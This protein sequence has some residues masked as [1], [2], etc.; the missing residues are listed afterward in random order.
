M[1][2][3]ILGLRE[4]VKKDG[5][6]G[7]VTRFFNKGWQFAKVEEVFSEKNV[8]DLLKN[9]PEAEKYNLYFTVADCMK[10]REMSFQEVI[11]FDV[12]KIELK[13]GS[14]EEKRNIILK[15]REILASLIPGAL[16]QNIASL[17]SGHG[18]QLF[19][20]IEEQ[21]LDKSVFNVYG[22]S[23]K[24]FCREYSRKLAD[25]GIV[26]KEVD[27][28]AFSSARLMRLPCTINRKKN[29]EDAESFLVGEYEPLKVPMFLEKEEVVKEHVIHDS[30]LRNYL[31]PDTKGVLTECHFLN[32]CKDN[33]NEVTEPQWYA[34]LSVVARLDGGHKLCHEYSNQYK[35]YDEHATDTKIQQ[36]LEAAG[37]RTCEGVDFVW[38]KCSGC[39]HYQSSEIRSPIQIK[40]PD[41]IATEATGF[42][43]LI[44]DE[45]GRTKKGPLSYSDMVKAY[46]RDHK[47]KSQVV[48]N[49]RN[50]ILHWIYIEDYW[51]RIHEGDIA[52]WV[53][54]VT[55]G[56]VKTHEVY[57]F[58]NKLGR[59]NPIPANFFEN[60]KNKYKQF[61]NCVLDLST[62][63]IYPPS[64]E[65]GIT[66][67]VPHVYN[68][69]M[70]CPSWDKFLMD[71]TEEDENKVRILNEFV[72][73]CLF[74]GNSWLQKALMLI[75]DGANGKSV[76]MHIVK[77]LIGKENCA[78]IKIKNIGKEDSIAQLGGK[79]VNICGEVSFDAFRDSA[80]FK[81]LV[82]GGTFTG[83]LQYEVPRDVIIYTKFIMAC[84]EAP[85]VYDQSHGFARRLLVIVFNREFTPETEGHDPFIKE[86][87]E[88][89]I[90]GIINRV[91]DAYKELVER[92]YFDEPTKLKLE[93]DMFLNSSNGVTEFVNEYFEKS[94]DDEEFLKSSI[95]QEMA[96]QYAEI[97]NVDP[98]MFSTRRI[99]AEF[100]R[101]F[102]V[103][104]SNTKKVK[105]KVYRGYCGIKPKP[106]TD[107]EVEDNF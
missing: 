76:F 75:G 53:E 86:K 100:K 71:V 69:E 15:A 41:Y 31:K 1:P 56:E 99:A 81:E 102:R 44:V 34:M 67:V 3:Q 78:S 2:I 96:N 14:L 51:R 64:P 7:I 105:G 11:P 57:E 55:K 83:R 8:L 9:V 58:I 46:N 38:G 59:N 88:R 26:H 49:G 91:S 47:Y 48:G 89:E 17:W 98:R 66:H 52:Q 42:R 23:Y 40:S 93:K 95:I 35:G 62:G 68:K 30:V 45:N 20:L 82:E 70:K 36:A 60:A 13:D 33:Q 101:K 84:N 97:M 107:I 77:E 43:P 65:F 72:G 104:G 22:T 106:D 32:W 74:S 61:M 5:K 21:L 73:Y 54:K 27:T 19:V 16:P 10:E 85:R 37:P 28:T 103:K 39:P 4:I 29:L 79:L 50:G 92:G 63:D 90:P 6:K 25:A 12:D 24:K 18:A 87:L 80:D 94:N